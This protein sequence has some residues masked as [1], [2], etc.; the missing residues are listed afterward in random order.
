MKLPNTCNQSLSKCIEIDNEL[1]KL[2]DNYKGPSRR[3]KVFANLY[4]YNP[5]TSK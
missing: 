1:S 5:N 4:K 2:L 3:K